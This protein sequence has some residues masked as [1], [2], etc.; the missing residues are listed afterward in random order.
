M[1]KITRMTEP[2]V[3]EHTRFLIDK[4]A[5]GGG[6]ALGTGNSPADYVPVDNFLTMIEEGFL[7]NRSTA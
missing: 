3:R 6:W 2:Q 4:C 5:P 1:D 7:R